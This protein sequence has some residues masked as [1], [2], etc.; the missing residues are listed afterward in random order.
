[1]SGMDMCRLGRLEN[2]LS[3]DAYKAQIKSC[4][5]D[6]YQEITAGDKITRLAAGTSVMLCDSDKGDI[7]RVPTSD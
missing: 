4:N 3:E 5:A 2:Q 6:V 1:M 7:R